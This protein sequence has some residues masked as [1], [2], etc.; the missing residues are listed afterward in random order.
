MPPREIPEKFLVAFSFAGEQRDLVRSIAEAVEARLGRSKVFFDE[1][2][3]DYIA[4]DDADILLQ[5]IYCER[6]HLTVVCVS[7]RYEGKPWTRA[8]HAAIRARVNRSRVSDSDKE[9]LGVLPIRVGDGEVKG[10]PT[11]TSIVPDVRSRSIDKTAELIINRLQRAAPQI[12]QASAPPAHSS[13]PDEPTPYEP[14][15]ADRTE[16]WPGIQKLMTAGAAKRILI[17]KGLSGHSKSALLNAAFRYAKILRVPAGYV[18]FKDTTCLSQPNVLKR[19]RL[20]LDAVLP[21]VTAAK[22]LDPFTL[23]GD[24]RKLTSPALILLDTYEKVTESKELA[25]WI[26]TQLL[27]EVEQCEHLR[28]LIGGQK[29]PERAARWSD[30][31]EEIELKK[32][33]D[34][35]VWKE[36]AQQKNQRVDEKHI[37]GFVLVSEGVP[38]T[39]SDYLT[40]LAEKLTPTTA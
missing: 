10:I 18:D 25:D 4:G 11:F 28:F 23:L 9:R 13:W 24:L 5:G 8:E 15:L 26:E 37:E 20:E 19:L 7:E 34:Q 2:Y 36:W 29:V 12:H 27:V 16:E 32:I 38:G 22:E 35:Q 30:L 6:C 39:I 31:A 17:F 3:E 40:T 21:A 14:G 1:W 33:N